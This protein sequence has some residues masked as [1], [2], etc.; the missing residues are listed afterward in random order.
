M[1]STKV[2][3]NFDPLDATTTN[4]NGGALHYGEA[5]MLY[6]PLGTTFPAGD[7]KRNSQTLNILLDKIIRINKHRITP[8]TILSTPESRVETRLSGRE[9]SATFSP[10]PSIPTRVGSS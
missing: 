9:G 5:G 10:S 6:A 1:G 3:L 7:P 2:L 8:R 4:H